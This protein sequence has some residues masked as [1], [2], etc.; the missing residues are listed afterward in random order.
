MSN[1]MLDL[2]TLGNGSNAVIIAIGACKFDAT[3][4]T[5]KFYTNI[6]PQSCVDAGLQMDASTVMWWMK[7]SDEARK[8]FTHGVPLKQALEAFAIWC[9]KPKTVWGNGAAFDN[10]ILSNAYR[11]TG[12]VQPWPYWADM[13]YRTVKNL[14]KDVAMSRSGTHH[15]AVDDAVSQALHL[16]EICYKRGIS[17]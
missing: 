4:V 5:E 11:L 12:I 14:N 3:G 10:V 7:Q 13:C 16:V 15:N 17:L 8:V 9:G 1:I 2:E 6:D